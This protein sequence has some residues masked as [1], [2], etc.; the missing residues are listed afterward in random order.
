MSLENLD[1][2]YTTRDII[3]R[4]GVEREELPRF[5]DEEIDVCGGAGVGGGIGVGEGGDVGVF[6]RGALVHGGR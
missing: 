4:D 2:E 1:F 6:Q 5:A 3:C